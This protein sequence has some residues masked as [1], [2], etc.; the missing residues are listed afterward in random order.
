MNIKNIVRKWNEI[1]EA[2]WTL[3]DC[4]SEIL[5]KLGRTDYGG[6]ELC[7]IIL[8]KSRTFAICNWYNFLDWLESKKLF[9]YLGILPI[10]IK[11]NLN[12]KS[13]YSKK[14]HLIILNLF[15]WDIFKF[16]A[17][18]ACKEKNS[19]LLNSKTEQTL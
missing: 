6:V 9:G 11:Y 2:I 19:L 16:I 13:I 1:I 12:K 4:L 7:W 17:L 10:R 3:W 5:G 14:N 8:F 18:S 15:N